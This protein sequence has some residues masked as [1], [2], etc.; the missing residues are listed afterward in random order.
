M[1]KFNDFEKKRINRSQTYTDRTISDKNSYCLCYN[2]IK[3]IKKNNLVQLNRPNRAIPGMDTYYYWMP[4]WILHDCCRTASIIII[5][6]DASNEI[7]PL[8]YNSLVNT[9][10]SI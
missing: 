7:E 4:L 8:V 5:F 2:A 9:K 6:I 10:Y 1:R 3:Y